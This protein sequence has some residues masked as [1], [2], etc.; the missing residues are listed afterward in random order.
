MKERA[1][2]VTHKIMSAIKS[3]DTK[4]EIFFRKALWKWGIR[5]R[6]PLKTGCFQRFPCG[7]SPYGLRNA[8]F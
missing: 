1:K 8:H 2:E 7:F 6:E 3:K 5:Y 4:P